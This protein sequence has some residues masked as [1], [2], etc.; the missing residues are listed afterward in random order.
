MS[1]LV[2]AVLLIVSAFASVVEI[3]VLTT[4]AIA[5]PVDT[6]LSGLDRHG[7]ALIVVAGFALVMLAGAV[8]RGA[9]PAMIAVVAAGAL[10]LGISAISDGPKL[11]DTGQVGQLYEDASAKAGPGFYEETLGGALLLIA[12]GGMLLLGTAG[13]TR[14]AGTAPDAAAASGAERVGAKR[15]RSGA[16]PGTRAA[17]DWFSEDRT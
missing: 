1:G 17:D 13:R 2:G 16:T 5:A 14:R 12:G 11:D 8:L 7:P 3:D 6:R 10:A 4:N 15:P 9:R